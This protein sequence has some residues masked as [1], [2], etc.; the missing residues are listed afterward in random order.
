MIE[1]LH[2]LELQILFF[3]NGQFTH[4]WADWF[5]IHVTDLHKNHVFDVLALAALL[6]FSIR[7]YRRRSWRVILG[8]ALTI[9]IGDAVGYRVLK[10]SIDR[11]RPFHNEAIQSRIIQRSDAHGNSFPSN[12]AINCFGAAAVLSVAF[13]AASYIFYIFAA[14]VGYSRLYLGVHY[15]SDVLAGALVGFFIARLVA[16]F[17]VNQLKDF[18]GP[19]S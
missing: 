7:K 2:Q 19:K 14:I 4:P 13:P 1:W 15:P 10:K 3:V 6:F 12:H 18:T 16:L 8:L 17:T 5:F 9:A 11:P